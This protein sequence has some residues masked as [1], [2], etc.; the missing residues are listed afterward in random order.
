MR[1][2]QL[3]WATC[4]CG[5]STL[6]ILVILQEDQRGLICCC[7]KQNLLFSPVQ[8]V[9]ADS[10]AH[11]NCRP[12]TCLQCSQGA[13]QPRRKPPLLCM[14]DPA[15]LRTCTA[16]LRLVFVLDGTKPY[17]LLSVPCRRQSERRI[18]PLSVKA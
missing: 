8:G 5:L 16:R 1:H 11:A 15:P 4:S 3:L 17:F 2:P 10:K 13:S 6:I 18:A 7:C 14:P 12:R 9:L